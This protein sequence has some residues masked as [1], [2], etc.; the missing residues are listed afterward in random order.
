MDDGI[1]EYLNKRSALAARFGK[2]KRNAGNIRIHQPEREQRTLARLEALNA[3][4]GGTLS[5]HDIERVWHVLLQISRDIPERH[6][7]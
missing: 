4:I 7:D 5:G 3:Q 2:L 1:L 6:D